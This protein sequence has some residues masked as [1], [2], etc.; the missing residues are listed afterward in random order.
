MQKWHF[1]Y[2]TSDIS[3]TKQVYSQSY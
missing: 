3:K 2:I 1:R